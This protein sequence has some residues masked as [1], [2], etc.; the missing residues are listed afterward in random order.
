VR[1]T[2]SSTRNIPNIDLENDIQLAR[3]VEEIKK[4]IK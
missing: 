4:Q 2:L 3:A 1:R